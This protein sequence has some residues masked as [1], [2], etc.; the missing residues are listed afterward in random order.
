MAANQLEWLLIDVITPPSPS[1]A[2]P[3]VKRPYRGGVR[4]M[5]YVLITIMWTLQKR[6]QC[7]HHDLVERD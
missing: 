4:I 1:F 6:G 5:L 7:Y 2:P 3:C